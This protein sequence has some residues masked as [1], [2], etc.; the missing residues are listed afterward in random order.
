MQHGMN[1][2]FTV[3]EA[4][5]GPTTSLSA[6]YRIIFNML[7]FSPKLSYF[8]GF[9]SGI[10]GV[11]TKVFYAKIKNA[12]KN[13][14]TETYLATTLKIALIFHVGELF[15]NVSYILPYLITMASL[16]YQCL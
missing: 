2:L 3:E 15:V 14:W 10:S 9:F 6:L 13:R 8:S 7:T 12:C 16:V 11:S 1:A 4:Q 5:A